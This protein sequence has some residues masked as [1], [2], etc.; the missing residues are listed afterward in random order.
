MAANEGFQSKYERGEHAEM[1]R[2]SLGELEALEKKYS[3]VLNGSEYAFSKNPSEEGYRI[4]SRLLEAVRAKISEVKAANGHVAQESEKSRKI[5]S[6]EVRK[7]ISKTVDAPVSKD[8]P[9]RDERIEERPAFT[10]IPLAPEPKSPTPTGV[11]KSDLDG[12]A[13]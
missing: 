13:G 3:S 1:S 8:V 6:K 9:K 4:F 11:K 5:L 7:P 10:K 12:F 2:A